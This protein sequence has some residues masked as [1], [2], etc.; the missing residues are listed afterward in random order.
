[1]VCPEGAAALAAAARLRQDG[2]IGRD[3]TVAV[4]NTG[5]GLLYEDSLPG[6]EARLLAA[7]ESLPAGAAGRSVAGNRRA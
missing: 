1:V 6:R 5:T 2:W 3:E 7:G 4:F